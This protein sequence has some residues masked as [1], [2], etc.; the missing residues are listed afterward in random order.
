M[1]YSQQRFEWV[2]TDSV[3]NII[4]GSGLVKA[5]LSLVN[6]VSDVEI[7]C[8]PRRSVGWRVI[9][10]RKRREVEMVFSVLWPG[11]PTCYFDQPIGHLFYWFCSSWKRYWSAVTEIWGWKMKCL[12]T[13]GWHRLTFLSSAGPIGSFC[14]CRWY[15]WSWYSTGSQFLVCWMV[16]PRWA[17]PP[18]SYFGERGEIC[19]SCQ[20][21]L[22]SLIT[23]LNPPQSGETFFSAGL[24]MR[25]QKL[26]DKSCC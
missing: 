3:S 16:F 14:L 11:P 2:K 22:S 8:P 20:R 21:P 19:K 17:G 12:V 26:F 13:S 6:E 18:G 4:I 1:H 15:W 9:W 7:P 24:G 10:G 23:L 5:P 25:L